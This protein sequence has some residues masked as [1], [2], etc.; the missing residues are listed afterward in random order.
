MQNRSPLRLLQQ[1][2]TVGR[3]DEFAPFRNRLLH[4]HEPGGPF[5]HL[6]SNLNPEQAVL[7]EESIGRAPL[8]EYLRDSL[9]NALRMKFS[10]LAK[11]SDDT[12]YAL[13]QSIAQRHAELKEI[14]NSEIPANRRAIEEA[15]E[16]GDLRENFEYK[17]ARQ[18][19]EYLTARAETLQSS[20][21][22]A[23]PIDLTAIETETVRVGVTLILV[24]S[25]GAQEQLSLL[26]PWESDPERKIFSYQSELGKSLLSGRIGDQVDVFGGTYQIES[27]QAY[28][29]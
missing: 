16:M 22:R 3:F 15:R 23:Q 21:N 1:I 10:N 20:L 9:L 25:E 2:L 7:A 28:S 26:G 4:L 6:L 17:S 18:R 11:S 14:L 29:D 13:P 24:N 5:P 8:E 27:I 19:H 12:M